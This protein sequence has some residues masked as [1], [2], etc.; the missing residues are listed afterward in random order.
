VR[1]RRAPQFIGQLGAISLL[2]EQQDGP[3]WAAEHVEQVDRFAGRLHSPSAETMQ[4]PNAII[5]EAFAAHKTQ[6]A[7]HT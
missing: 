5:D 1:N 7:G 6:T 2:T 3:V 4:R